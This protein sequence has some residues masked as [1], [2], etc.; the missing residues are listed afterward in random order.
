MRATWLLECLEGFAGLEGGIHR[1][2]VIGTQE[3]KQKKQDDHAFKHVFQPQN[4]G[5]L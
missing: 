2:D 3:P 5:G 4:G 1:I